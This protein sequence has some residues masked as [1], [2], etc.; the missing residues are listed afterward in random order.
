MAGVEPAA[1]GFGVRRAV[2]EISNDFRILLQSFIFLVTSHVVN[3]GHTG[4]VE[5]PS[6]QSVTSRGRSRLLLVLSDQKR[7][8]LSAEPSSPRIGKRRKSTGGLEELDG[9]GRNRSKVQVVILR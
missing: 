4:G 2:F 3:V 7:K 8:E 6:D 5:G 9:H 1:F